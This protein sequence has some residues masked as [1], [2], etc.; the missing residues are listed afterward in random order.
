MKIFKKLIVVILVAGSLPDSVIASNSGYTPEHRLKKSQDADK[1]NG[2]MDSVRNNIASYPQMALAYARDLQKLAIDLNDMPS[3]I[4]GLNFEC[5]TLFF[6]GELDPARDVCREAIHISDSLND[7]KR[8]AEATYLEGAIKSIAENSRAGLGSLLKGYQYQS[9]IQDTLGMANSL[10]AIGATYFDLA[11]YDS[12]MFHLLKAISIAE[13]N[14]YEQVLSKAYL[15]MG[16]VY[17]ALEEFQEAKSCFKKSINLNRNQN[18]LINLGK[19]YQNLGNILGQEQDYDSAWTLY[20]KA[21]ELSLSVSN[22]EG[23]AHA[24]IGLGEVAD[25][26]GDY[27]KG[28]YLYSKARDYYKLCN[29]RQGELISYK[30]MGFMKTRSGK[31]DEA[32][33]VFDSSLAIARDL[34]LTKREFEIYENIC[35]TY[36]ASGDY[37][38]AYRTYAKMH[39]LADSIMNVDKRERIAE[40]EIRYETEKKNARILAL[41]NQNLKL[42]N[43]NISYLAGGS[44]VLMV[45]VFLFA[46]NSQRNRKNRIISEQRILQ[47]EEEKKLLA[48]RSIVEGQEEERKRIAREL[49]DGLGVLLSSARMHFV[50]IRDKSPDTEPLLEQA[51]KLLE[52]ATGDVRRI[53][54]NMMPGLLTKYGF[55]EA[56]QELFEQLDD[57]K[58]I[59]PVLHVSGKKDRL[60]ENTEIMLYRIIQEMVNN[61]LKHARASNI[62]LDIDIQLDHLSLKYS[63]DG[64]GF[65][66]EQRLRQKTM[67]LTGLQS[68]VKFLGGELMIQT[69]P[70]KGV[71]IKF[72]VP[73]DRE[74]KKE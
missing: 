45:L 51:D 24:Y 2:L 73:V 9:Q 13:R 33:V 74:S 11:V 21:L 1:I 31:Y 4:D 38:N 8:L 72:E 68:R 25:N 15:N 20:N 63:D 43:R 3:Y 18:H 7:V 12:A 5:K 30:N 6:L 39:L 67:G 34:G 57:I 48:A 19:S 53:S 50:S 59:H 32:M 17:D 44:S 22:M 35:D 41:Q 37:Q 65:D 29:N 46:F 71:L 14:G 26:R 23:V 49:H 61:T 69:A 56:I 47:L 42:E 54:H 58:D 52:Q 64:Q 60:P 70:G 16:L 55:Y 36:V 62:T 28:Y 40:L 10:N 66:L 27:Q